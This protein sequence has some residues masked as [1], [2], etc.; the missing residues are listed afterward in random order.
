MKLSFALALLA[1]TAAWA[2]DPVPMDIKTGQ[3]EY[4]VTTQMSGM[5]QAAAGK[6][7][8][9]LTPDQLAKIPPEQRARIEAMMKGA[10]GQPTT[11]VTK[12]CVKKEDLAKLNPNANQDQ[13]CKMTVT[14]SSRTKQ[15]IHMDC[16]MNGN[17]Q[18][19]TAVFEALSSESMKFNVQV[20]ATNNGQPM[21]M[22]I[23][24]TSKWLGDTCTDSK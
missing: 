19:G 8:P 14:S 20:S 23:N 21:N 5:T 17:K 18:T 22:T 10:G 15:E 7:M 2:A 11:T 12:R 4:T 16:E 9:Q 3:W 1:G 6:Q 24:G 13:S